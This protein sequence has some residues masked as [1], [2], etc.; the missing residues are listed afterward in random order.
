MNQRLQLGKMI[1][2]EIGWDVFERLRR[3]A[4]SHA[5][6]IDGRIPSRKHVDRGI[7]N[8]PRPFSITFV[9]CEDLKNSDWVRFF[10]VKAIPA[11]YGLEVLID[12]KPGQHRATEV[13][14]LVRQDG[15]L[16]VLE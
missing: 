2:Q 16:A 10:M 11:I 12:A 13:N 1:D 7:A 14:G 6:G 8:H 9:V 15:Q 5:A 3:V 4:V